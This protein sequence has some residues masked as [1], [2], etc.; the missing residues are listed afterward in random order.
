MLDLLWEI[1]CISQVFAYWYWIGIS[2]KL[3]HW[4]IYTVDTKSVNCIKYPTNSCKSFIVRKGICF[5]SKLLKFLK[6]NQLCVYGPIYICSFID[7]CIR[8]CV[9][10]VLYPWLRCVIC[11]IDPEYFGVKKGCIACMFTIL[12]SWYSNI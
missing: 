11:T 3:L 9:V 8:V 6:F 2:S 7:A 1:P 12:T 5:G 10:C 4:Y